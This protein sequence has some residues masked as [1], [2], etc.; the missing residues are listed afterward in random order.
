EAVP[1]E[2]N[3]VSVSIVG[4]KLSRSVQIQD[5]GATITAGAG[6]TSTNA[7]TVR[8]ATGSGQPT[9]TLISV[10]LDDRSDSLT[11]TGV[12]IPFTALG[13][14]GDDILNGGSGN[15][16]LDGGQGDDNLNGGAGIDTASWATLPVVVGAVIV[17]LSI[18]RAFE[19]ISGRDVLSGIENVVGSSQD[20]K[21][22]CDGGA[23]VID[24]AGGNDV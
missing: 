7:N 9:A 14:P 8:C 2:I 20:D 24:G 19:G 6:C 16:V 23:N 22:Y 12:S 21:L 5:T 3:S 4:I 17:D 1:G 10:D 13:G 11:S 15:D 18:G